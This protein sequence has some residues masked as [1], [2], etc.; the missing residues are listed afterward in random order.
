MD[1]FTLKE[2]LE[3]LDTA[4][5]EMEVP[6]MA[7][8]KKILLEKYREIDERLAEEQQVEFSFANPDELELE[9]G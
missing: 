6:E 8:A 3:Q 5:N 2:K 7:Y 9:R 4:L 1:N